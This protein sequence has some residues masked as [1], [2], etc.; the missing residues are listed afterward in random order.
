[1]V[2]TFANISLLRG[3]SGHFCVSIG[4][5]VFTFSWVQGMTLNCFGCYGKRAYHSTAMVNPFLVGHSTRGWASARPWCSRRDLI[6]QVSRFL[7]S[8]G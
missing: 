7:G 5:A 4:I 2:S 3:K 1:M 8:P 6:D